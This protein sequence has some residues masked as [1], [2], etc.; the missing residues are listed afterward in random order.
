MAGDYDGQIELFYGPEFASAGI[1]ADV[2]DKAYGLTSGDYDNDG[3]IDF[4]AGDRDG[5]LELF[6]NNGSGGFSSAGIIADIGMN[7]W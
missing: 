6:L 2:G 5:E 7:A 3:D 1:I 4:V